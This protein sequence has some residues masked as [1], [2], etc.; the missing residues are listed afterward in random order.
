MLTEQLTE[1]LKKAP[2]I[3]LDNVQARLQADEPHLIKQ[4]ADEHGE[5][6]YTHGNPQLIVCHAAILSQQR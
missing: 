5:S 4:N 6:R 3:A 2:Q 1:H